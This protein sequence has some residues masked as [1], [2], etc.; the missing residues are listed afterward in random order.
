MVCTAYDSEKKYCNHLK[1]K[2]YEGMQRPCD[3][4]PEPGKCPLVLMREG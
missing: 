3:D 4:V 2:F 1:M